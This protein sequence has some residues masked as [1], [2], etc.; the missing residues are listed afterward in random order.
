MNRDEYREG[1]LYVVT[2]ERLRAYVVTIELRKNKEARPRYF[3]VI[4]P[5]STTSYDNWK[6][7]PAQTL[8]LAE[9]PRDSDYIENPTAWLSE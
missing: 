1:P 2:P 6:G 3:G 5:A 7:A 4:M 9:V 8:G